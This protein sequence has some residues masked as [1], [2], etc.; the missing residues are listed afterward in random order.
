M[1]EVTG[2]VKKTPVVRMEEFTEAGVALILYGLRY[3]S[4]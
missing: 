2:S 3:I 4:R 1:P